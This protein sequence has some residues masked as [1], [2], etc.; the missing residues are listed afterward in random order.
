MLTNVSTIILLLPGSH[1]VTRSDAGTAAK[2]VALAVLLVVVLLPLLLPPLVVT[3]LGHRADPLLA[4]HNRLVVGHQRA[5]NAAVCF[6]LAALL[7]SRL[8]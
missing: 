2:A 8:V 3:V 7:A 1:V 6:L 4:S 5:L